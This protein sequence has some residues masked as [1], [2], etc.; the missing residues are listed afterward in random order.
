LEDLQL[1]NIVLV[2]LDQKDQGN[3]W[4]WSQSKRFRVGCAY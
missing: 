2:L 4:K 1:I 3:L